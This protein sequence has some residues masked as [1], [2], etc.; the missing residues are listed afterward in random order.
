MNSNIKVLNE[1][2]C[3]VDFKHIHSEKVKNLSL[4]NPKASDYFCFTLDGKIV[5]NKNKAFHEDI[6]SYLNILMKFKEE[7]LGTV[8]GF[9]DFIRIFIPKANNLTDQA[10][11]K[12][13]QA[14]QL[15]KVQ[16]QFNKISNIEKNRRTIKEEYTKG[17]KKLNGIDK[18]KKIFKRKG[19]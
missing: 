9:H 5:I 14:S 7:Q 6:I 17:I 3:L 18:I 11:E 8:Q 13:V 15:D 12:F 16:E 19:V 10:F 4:I 2:L 1:N